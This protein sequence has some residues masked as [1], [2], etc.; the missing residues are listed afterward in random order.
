MFL[1]FIFRAVNCTL[2][3]VYL[4]LFLIAGIDLR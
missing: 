3:E 4:I 2:A 1:L